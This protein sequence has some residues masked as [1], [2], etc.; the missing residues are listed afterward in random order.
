ML[1][2]ARHTHDLG[3]SKWDAFDVDEA[4]A[5][6][7][8]PEP[9]TSQAQVTRAP[10]APELEQL[11]SQGA[12]P[13]ELLDAAIAR[14]QGEEAPVSDVEVGQAEIVSSEL[15]TEVETDEA[16]A[17]MAMAEAGKTTG[18]KLSADYQK[19]EDFE[20]DLDDLDDDECGMDRCWDS[21]GMDL[22]ALSGPAEEVK[23]IQAHWRREAV[24]MAKSCKKMKPKGAT[25]GDTP[26][27]PTGDTLDLA[28]VPSPASALAMPSPV[29]IVQERPSVVTSGGGRLEQ[30]YSKW[31]NFDADAALLEL[32]NEDTTEEGKTMRLSAGQ[33]S[34]MLNCEGYTKDREEYD[35]DQDIE[36]NMGG[37]KK[38]IAQNFKD[39]SGLKTEGNEL[40][41]SGQAQE[42]ISKYQEGLETL[43]L[44]QQAS[45]LMSS[46]LADKQSCLV[47]DLWKNLSAA[48]LAAGDFDGALRSADEAL[49]ASPAD[50]KAHYRR[51][52]A[53]LRL[54]RKEEA[55]KELDLMA[56]SDPAVGRLRK[57]LE[58]QS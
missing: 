33:G 57:E 5:E 54:Q 34:A 31:K 26:K 38:I 56:S 3:Y 22:N 28:E 42:A 7:D 55:R 13:R 15:E 35:L 16:M 24:R 11:K 46:S 19:W 14:L 50:N 9:K 29:E 40:L 43:Q 52:T 32:D 53:L 18:H 37:L 30:N 27:P 4:L 48:Q 49:Q 41:K 58:Q 2:A 21:S 44:A 45:V 25:K 10:L 47:C 1:S 23:Q 20:E 36:R 6:V 39:A 51:A 12:E 8:R 17:P